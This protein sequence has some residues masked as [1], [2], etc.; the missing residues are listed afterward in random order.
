LVVSAVIS[1]PAPHRCGGPGGERRAS[2]AGGGGVG[3]EW[4]GDVAA[5]CEPRSRNSPRKL[6]RA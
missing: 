2:G 5:G 1:R 6:T 4:G 3:G